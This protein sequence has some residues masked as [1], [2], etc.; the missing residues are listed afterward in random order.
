MRLFRSCKSSLWS[1]CLRILAMDVSKCKYVFVMPQVEDAQA[2]MRLYTL[3][4]VRW[5]KEIKL[6]HMK[7][8][9]VKSAVRTKIDT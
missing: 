1:M 9:L 6:K 8:K 3:H 4:K 7:G 2:A 5:E